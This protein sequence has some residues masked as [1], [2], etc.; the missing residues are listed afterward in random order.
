M[1]RFV[2]TATV[3]EVLR[4]ERPLD[5]DLFHLSFDDGFRN[6][7][8]NA[9]PLLRRYEVPAIFFVPTALIAGGSDRASARRGVIEMASWA[10]LEQVATAGFEIGSHTRTHARF[11]AISRSSAA[12]EDEIFGSKA[13]IERRLGSCHYISW[14]YGRISDA[15]E[16]TLRAVEHAG[17]AACFGAFRGRVI[18]RQTLPFRIPRHHFEPHWPLSHVKYFARGGLEG[19][20][21]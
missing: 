13:D 3:L 6:I 20:P 1:G 10:D 8:T 7:L 16:T 9:L 12:V 15:D 18:P 14:P 4:G 2:D 17:Y 21:A 5:Q 11:A 19:A